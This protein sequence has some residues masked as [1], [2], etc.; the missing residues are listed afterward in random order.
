MAF[1]LCD[2]LVPTADLLLLATVTF[3]GFQ[4]TPA[5]LR[6]QTAGDGAVVDL[7]EGV[8]SVVEWL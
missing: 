4:Q 3:D 5:M 1:H 6:L 7:T 8:R 2:W